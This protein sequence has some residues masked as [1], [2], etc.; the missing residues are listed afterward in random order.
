MRLQ[1]LIFDKGAQKY[2]LEKRASSR[3]GAGKTG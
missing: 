2:A 1:H 3:Y